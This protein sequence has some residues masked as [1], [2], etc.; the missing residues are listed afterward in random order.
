VKSSERLPEPIFRKRK[1]WPQYL[2]LMLMAVG[3]AVSCVFGLAWLFVALV[4]SAFLGLNECGRWRYR[5]NLLLCMAAAVAGSI[6]GIFTWIETVSVFVLL[7]ATGGFM[8]YYKDSANRM[9]PVMEYI[10]SEL[11]RGVTLDETVAIA[12][13]KISEI[14]PG[15]NVAVA[16]ADGAGGLFLPERGEK[17]R[18]G[19]ARN[20]GAVW[21]VLASG[22]PYATDRV[23]PSKDMPLFRDSRSMISVPL[24]ARGEKLGVL[25]VESAETD[26]FP[27]DEHGKLTVIAFIVAQAI[28]AFIHD[29]GARQDVEPQV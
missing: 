1:F 15:C 3:G 20:G 7:F 19:L 13:E 6:C 17:A 4:V 28:G 11:S 9:L 22:R 5:T 12:C 26:A 25:Q 23:D 2:W 10:S 14:V 8:L 29:A 24:F 21:K 16:V 27:R 18:A